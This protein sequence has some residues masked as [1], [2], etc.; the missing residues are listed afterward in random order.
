MQA[1]ETP[2]LTIL[3]VETSWNILRSMDAALVREGK[4]NQ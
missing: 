4:L 1:S 3:K 2:L